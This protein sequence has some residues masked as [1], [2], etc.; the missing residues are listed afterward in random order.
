VPSLLGQTAKTGSRLRSVSLGND[1]RLGGRRYSDGSVDGRH[2]DESVTAVRP[3]P[4]TIP[5]AATPGMA[6]APNVEP[7]MAI[8][9][10]VT[11]IAL[12]LCALSL[13][14]SHS[15]AVIWLAAHTAND[16]CVA[17]RAAE[18]LNRKATGDPGESPAT[19]SLLLAATRRSEAIEIRRLT[20]G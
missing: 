1:A 10:A 12:L 8:A 15:M 9:A 19:V 13:C 18:E 7:P 17:P 2:N 5:R 14:Q 4:P 20:A 6:D 16:E 11:L 3:K